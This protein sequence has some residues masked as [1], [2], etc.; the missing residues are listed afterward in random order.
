MYTGGFYPYKTLEEFW[1]F[2]SRTIML[3]RY[4]DTDS[5]V[6]SDLLEILK[7]KNYFVLTT[8]VDHCFQKA[9]FDKMR[10]FYTQGD[11]GLFQCSKACHN[12]TYDNEK[13]IKE[14]SEKQTDMKIPSHLIPVCPVCGAP[15]TTNLRIDDT[16]VQD[17][18][19]YAAC[20]RYDDFV[21][22]YAKK[23][24]LLLELGVGFNTPGIIKYPFWKITSQNKKAFYACINNGEAV[25]PD[26]IADR[27][28]CIDSD[29][30]KVLSILKVKN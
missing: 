3:N 20:A 9:G 18:G 17:E 28:I 22:N 10:L 30:A 19:W 5:T 4:T 12:K 13:I 7:S 2:W 23:N 16:F 21:K 15:M 25:C 1:G 11:Y 27:S 6:Y 24:I 8:N 26:V 29:I 14:M